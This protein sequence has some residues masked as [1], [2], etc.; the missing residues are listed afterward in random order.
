V[1]IGEVRERYKYPS[2]HNGHLSAALPHS[3]NNKNWKTVLLA[4]WWMDEDAFDK[5]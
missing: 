4:I 3:P 5:I 2:L 1:N